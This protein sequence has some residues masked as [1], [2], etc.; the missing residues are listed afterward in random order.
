MKTEDEL[1]PVTLVDP[2]ERLAWRRKYRVRKRLQEAR[3]AGYLANP[4]HKKGPVA[5]RRPHVSEW[6]ALLTRQGDVEA[7]VAFLR[8]YEY[9]ER[10]GR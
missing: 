3:V 6:P 8:G 9:V 1:I 10:N 5:T 2:G 4:V 7:Q